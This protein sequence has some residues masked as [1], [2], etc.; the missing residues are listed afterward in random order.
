LNRL[1]LTTEGRKKDPRNSKRIPSF[2]LSGL[3]E[4]KNKQK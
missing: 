2:M 1:D 3:F 4:K